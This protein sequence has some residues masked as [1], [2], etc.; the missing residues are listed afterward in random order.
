MTFNGKTNNYLDWKGGIWR[1]E[2]KA[3][4]EKALH[5]KTENRS[6]RSGRKGVGVGGK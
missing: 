3:R 2:M 4:L 1:R 6:R 5:L